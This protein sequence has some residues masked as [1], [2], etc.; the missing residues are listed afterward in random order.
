L[1]RKNEENDKSCV[2]V[3][4]GSIKKEECKPSKENIPKMEKTQEED[5]IRDGYPRIPSTSK[6][7]RRFN[8][9]EGKNDQLRHEFRSTTSQRRTFSPRYQYLFYGYCFTCNNFVHKVVD[10]ISYGINVQ[11]RD[12]Y[13][14]PYNIECYKCHNYGH[15]YHD[16]R[17]IMNPSMKENINICTRKF[18]EGK[19]NK[20]NR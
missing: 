9:C 12:D 13:V 7:Q 5:Y 3:I 16:C 8:N 19:K 4:R 11:V 1:E 2:E 18:G 10:C 20:K 17:S 14:P 15:I 6:Y